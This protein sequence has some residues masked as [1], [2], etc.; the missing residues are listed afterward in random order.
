MCVNLVAVNGELAVLTIGL[1]LPRRRTSGGQIRMLTRS[2]VRPAIEAG[3]PLAATEDPPVP[4]LRWMGGAPGWSP[5]A[6]GLETRQKLSRGREQEAA[7]RACLRDRGAACADAR[8]QR[9]H[10][11]AV[12]HIVELPPSGSPGA[13]KA[14]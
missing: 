11:E 12:L 13:S 6:G 2:P 1:R 7:F 10:G 9:F 5:A 14:A 3:S 8:E 4:K